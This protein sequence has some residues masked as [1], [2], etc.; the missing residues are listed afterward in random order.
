MDKKHPKK[1]SGG[2]TSSFGITN[3]DC[4]YRR[5]Y[6]QNNADQDKQPPIV[7][8]KITAEEEGFDQYVGNKSC[9]SKKNPFDELIVSHIVCPSV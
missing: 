9:N 3:F 2:K 5:S 6:N 8:S 4:L 1:I 7:R